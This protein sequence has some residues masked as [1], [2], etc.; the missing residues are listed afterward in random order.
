MIGFLQALAFIVG[1]GA[2]V[3]PSAWLVARWLS[4]K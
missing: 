1:F 2:V 4:R 3:I